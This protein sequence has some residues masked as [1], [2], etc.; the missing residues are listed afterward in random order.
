MLHTAHRI[1]S[2]GV[3]ATLVVLRLQTGV[4][5]TASSE[6]AQALACRP[7]RRLALIAQRL[8]LVGAPAPA[9]GTRRLPL[10]V[11]HHAAWHARALLLHSQPDQCA[12]DRLACLIKAGE[13]KGEQSLTPSFEDRLHKVFTSKFDSLHDRAVDP[14]QT[15]FFFERTVDLIQPIRIA[16]CKPAQRSPRV[17]G[18]PRR[19]RAK[20]PAPGRAGSGVPSS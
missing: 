19:V 9:R 15:N 17:E 2:E 18:T 20:R 10:R 12:G 3:D 13:Q 1:A 4:L 16:F 8:Q 14:C 6:S 7:R 5:I 11:G